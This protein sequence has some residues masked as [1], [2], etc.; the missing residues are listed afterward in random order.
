MK[1]L[2]LAN[3]SSKFH[4]FIKL[5]SPVGKLGDCSGNGLDYPLSLLN[6]L[7][8]HTP[9]DV[10][11]PPME[12]FVRTVGM[13]APDIV[14]FLPQDVAI[15]RIT[16]LEE[17]LKGTDYDT[18]I[19]YME[20]IFTYVKNLDRVKARKVL[21]F[22][23]SPQQILL[24]VYDNIQADLVLKVVDKEGVMGFSEKLRKLGLKTEW[25]PLSVDGNRFKNLHLPRVYDYC[26]LGNLNPFVYPLRL[27]ALHY[28]FETGKGV[29]VNPVYGDEYV[30]A[31]NRSKMFVTC[32]GVCKF[33]VMKYYESM[34]C[35]ALL[36]ADEPMDAEELGFESGKNYVQFEDIVD[37]KEQSVYYTTHVA[38]AEEV[39]RAA[40]ELVR[41]R[42]TDEIR[43]RELYGM[44]Q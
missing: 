3:L 24:P 13:K 10:Y 34:A 26:L 17:L 14:N 20:S 32:S 40:E 16:D 2:F 11:S 35:G 31:I 37:L 25:L 44:L 7:A 28:L 42:H 27:K 4:G 23:S 15:P 6:E 19:L 9:I 29:M 39:R 41:K 22:M 30:K 21:W 12:K 43:A 33:P 5:P 8:K 38:E 1:T 36:F 18:V